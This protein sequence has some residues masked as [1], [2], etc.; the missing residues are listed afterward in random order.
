MTKD[1][2]GNTRK[3]PQPLRSPCQRI[4]PGR[5]RQGKEPEEEGQGGRHHGRGHIAPRSHQR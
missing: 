1:C 3:C 2:G 4:P 5:A